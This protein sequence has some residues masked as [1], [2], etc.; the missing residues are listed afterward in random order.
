MAIAEFRMP[1]FRVSIADR[2]WLSG[3]CEC[4]MPNGL[5]NVEWMP[6]VEY[7]TNVE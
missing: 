1:N 5:P 4:R 7:I 6:N 2:E 3:E